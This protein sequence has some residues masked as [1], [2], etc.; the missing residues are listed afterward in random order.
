MNGMWPSNDPLSLEDSGTPGF[1]A[2][3][4][5]ATSTG[6]TDA[7]IL[8]DMQKSSEISQ[9]PSDSSMRTVQTDR[10]SYETAFQE[11]QSS[12]TFGNEMLVP[13]AEDSSSHSA[14]QRDDTSVTTT[15]L[16]SLNNISWTVE[17]LD[18]FFEDG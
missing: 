18:Q 16:E 17:E 11:S 4:E 6:Y 13:T 1:T 7:F 3:T 12:T 8:P 14:E 9:A 5:F 2:S 10:G 15:V